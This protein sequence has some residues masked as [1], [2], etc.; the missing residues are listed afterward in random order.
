MTEKM[1]PPLA[2]ADL[3]ARLVG[4]DK[5]KFMVEDRWHTLELDTYL[6][7][8]ITDTNNHK[9]M[10]FP[11]DVFAALIELQMQNKDFLEDIG[12]GTD[13]FA[14]SQFGFSTGAWEIPKNF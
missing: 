2:P 1:H 11:Q 14:E 12:I 3:A 4:Y 10:G 5:I 13:D 9:R 7:K 6:N 8:L